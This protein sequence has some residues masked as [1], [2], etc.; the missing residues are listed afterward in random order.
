MRQEALPGIAAPLNLTERQELAL[1]LIAERAPISSEALGAAVR[2]ARG[3]RVSGAE[4]DRSNGRAL[5]EALYAKELVR[6]VRREGWVPASWKGGKASS[7]YD[8]RTAEV[9]Y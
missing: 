8:P 1:A 4:F 2:E 5:G 3:G 6:Y 9:P 7:G